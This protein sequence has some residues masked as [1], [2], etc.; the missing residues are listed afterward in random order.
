MAESCCNVLGHPSMIS[1]ASDELKSA[2]PLLLHHSEVILDSVVKSEL[3][4]SIKVDF[5]VVNYNGNQIGIIR[6]FIIDSAGTD[7]LEEALA[8]FLQPQKQIDCWTLYLVA[9][10]S[11]TINFPDISQKSL[12]FI[13]NK[14]L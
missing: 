1:E 6:L 9:K 5:H 4:A 13:I 8:S 2:V 3:S 7:G 14:V 12:S 11:L 10:Y